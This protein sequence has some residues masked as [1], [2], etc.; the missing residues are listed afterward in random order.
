[1][2][3]STRF[4]SPAT[5]A[6]AVI[7]TPLSPVM[8]NDYQSRSRGRGGK[9]V[10]GKRN[11]TEDEAL[12]PAT[13]G[14]RPCLLRL[15]TQGGCSIDAQMATRVRNGEAVA[16]RTECQRTGSAD[17]LCAWQLRSCS[18]WRASKRKWPT[19]KSCAA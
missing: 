1:M 13:A 15:F 9:S 12:H 2:A 4:F 8:Q 17:S 18:D 11:R 16:V 14:Q 6:G 19:S 7:D 10:A 3:S 5:G